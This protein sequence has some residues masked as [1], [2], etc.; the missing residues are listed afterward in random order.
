MFSFAFV[1]QVNADLLANRH[2]Y[3]G[4]TIMGNN[5]NWYIEEQTG[6]FVPPVSANYSFYVRGDDLVS[7]ELSTTSSPNDLKLYFGTARKV[8]QGE[9]YVAN[10]RCSASYSPCYLPTHSIMPSLP[11]FIVQATWY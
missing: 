9:L 6:F 3:Y 8:F 1:S 2:F 4:G 11:A 10:R 7:V 5:L